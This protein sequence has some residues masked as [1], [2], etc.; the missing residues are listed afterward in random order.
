MDVWVVVGLLLVD[1]RICGYC[2]NIFKTSTEA[3]KYADS[4]SYPHVLVVQRKLEYGG[5]YD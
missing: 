5:S 2:V 3:H 4:I 1:D